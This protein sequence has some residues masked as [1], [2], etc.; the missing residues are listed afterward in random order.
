M[1]T[2]PARRIELI[3][4]DLSLAESSERN[5]SAKTCIKFPTLRTW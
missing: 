4:R 5:G 1:W 3:D 2:P